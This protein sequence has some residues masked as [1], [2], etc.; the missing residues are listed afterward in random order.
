MRAEKPRAS[1]DSFISTVQM[2]DSSG[3]RV[4]VADDDPIQRD[5]LEIAL[6]GWGYDVVSVANGRAA[7]DLLRGDETFSILVTDWLMPELDG[8]DLCRLVR[9]SKRSRYLP[10]LL[11]TSRTRHEDLVEGL[12]AGADA[13]LTKPFD[14]ALLL[15]QIRTAERILELEHRLATQVDELRS[16]NQRLETD[17]SAAAEVQLSLLPEPAPSINGVDFGW[18]Y[19]ACDQLGG[20]MFNVFP[21]DE[22]HVGMYVLDV[23]GHGTPAALQSVTLSHVLTPFDVPGAMLKREIGRLGGY[24]VVPPAEVAR[25][26]NSH[27]P[28]IERS[29]QFFSFMY[30]VLDVKTRLVRY[31]CAGHPGPIVVSNGQVRCLEKGDGIPVGIADD[32]VYTEQQVQLQAGD[33]LVFYTDGVL[34][35]LNRTREAFG[36]DR[37]VDALSP[38]VPIVE[39]LSR[40]HARLERFEQGEPRHDDVTIVGLEVG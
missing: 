29:G 1:R 4:L 32:A 3:V 19:Q 17:L 13:F 36:L 37:L 21:L 8:T 2:A 24:S 40:L 28:L 12:N 20:D 35:T 6:E 30:A 15:A 7:W 33:Q 31:V 27:F 16:V 10:I 22:Q 9:Q 38:Q 39:S 14:R 23:S 26:L 5:L 18:V 25:K 11:Q 34:E